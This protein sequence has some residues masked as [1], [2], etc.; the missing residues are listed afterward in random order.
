M[1]VL[2]PARHGE[3][4][5]RPDHAAGMTETVRHRTQ[6][7]NRVQHLVVQ[8][9]IVGR[10]VVEPRLLLNEPMAGAKRGGGLLQIT[11]LAR[12]GPEIFQ[13]LFE[14]AVAANAGKA[15]TGGQDP[16]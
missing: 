11:K 10:D 9:K 4:Q 15:K 14:F 12:A 5:I 2:A 3:I 8:R 13:R 16:G 1:R 7:G 6:H